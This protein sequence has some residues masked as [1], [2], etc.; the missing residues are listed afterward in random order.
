MFVD[1]YSDSFQFSVFYM[2][3]NSRTVDQQSV[4]LFFANVHTNISKK[5][6]ASVAGLLGMARADLDPSTHQPCESYSPNHEWTGEAHRVANEVI[7][8]LLLA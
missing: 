5:G 8:V 1:A 3:S 2:F 6:D 7:S 4:S